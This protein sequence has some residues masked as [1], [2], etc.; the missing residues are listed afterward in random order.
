M[1]VDAKLIDSYTMS[2]LE[3]SKEGLIV[4]GVPAKWLRCYDNQRLNIYI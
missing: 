3:L 1:S 2:S 4:A